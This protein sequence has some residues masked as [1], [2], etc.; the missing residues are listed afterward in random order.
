[1]SAPELYAYRERS[2]LFEDIAGVYPIDANLTEVDEPERVEILLVSPSYF[3]LLGVQPQLGR[4]FN[5]DEDD[6]PGIAEIVVLSDACGSDGLA[7]APTPSARKLRIDKRLVR[8]RRRDA[9]RLRSPGTRAPLRHRHVGAVRL[10]RGAVC[11]RSK[12]RAA[13]YPLTGAIARLKAG[14]TLA[15]ARSVSTAFARDAARN[16]TRRLPGAPRLDAAPRGLHDDVVGQA[17]TPL[18]VILASVGVVLLIACANIAGL[19]LARSAGRYRELGIRRALGASRA[20]ARAL[21]CSSRASCSRVPGASPD[22]CSRCGPETSS[23][24][25]R[26]RACLGSTQVSFDAPRLVVRRR[27]I[28]GNRCALRRRP[29]VAV[30]EARRS[31]RAEGRA[32]GV[33]SGAAIGALGARRSPSS[34]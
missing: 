29:C 25:W 13:S 3:S 1:M 33:G 18:V 24:R 8:G 26:P 10:S 7:A 16:S 34:R 17:R 30:L 6:A 9:A 31:R 21:C 4:V 27:R 2:D 19:L 12:D 23:S 14:V 20:A 22:C 32:C 28:G 11:V 5:A 15:D